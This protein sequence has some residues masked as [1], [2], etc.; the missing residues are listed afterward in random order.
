M[1]MGERL[2]LRASVDISKFTPEAQ[3]ILKA[4]KKHGMFVADN[5]IEWAV[6]IAPDPRIPDLSAELR[7]VKGGDFEVIEFPKGYTPPTN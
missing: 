3:T 4:L 1:R 2:R 6:S 7:K 5:G